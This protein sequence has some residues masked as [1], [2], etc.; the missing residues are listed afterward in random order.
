[1]KKMKKRTI[2]LAAI[3]VFVSAAFLALGAKKNSSKTTSSPSPS[4]IPVVKQIKINDK[5]ITV[6]IADTEDSRTK[7]LTGLDKLP[8]DEGMLFIFESKNVIPS[9][10][11]KG[12]KFP[13][14]FIWIKNGEVA[15]I[16]ANISYP[17]SD[18]LDN[19]IKVYIPNSPVD[20]VLEVNA[21]FSGTNNI[22][23]GDKVYLSL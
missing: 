23:V 16:D 22:K 15:Q 20:Y 8:Q 5:N 17:T 7:G 14:D 13:L 3:V 4:P 18:T 2:F 10:W 1:M 19:A 11:M 9:F 6:T 21:G 12:M